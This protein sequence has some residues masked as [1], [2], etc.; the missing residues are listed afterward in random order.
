MTEQ[1][2]FTGIGQVL[3]TLR[4]MSPEQACLDNTDIDTRTDIYA[5]G[6]ILYELLTGTTPLEDSSI[7]GQAALRVLEL[8]REHE[9]LKPSRRLSNSTQVAV[10]T[11]T[12]KRRTDSVRLRRI[13]SGDL[14]WIVM[15]A[16]EKD[17]SRRYDS[18]SGFA[19]DIRRYVN[20]EPVAARPPSISYQLKKF[21]R[22]NRVA[23]T[24]GAAVVAAIV[25]GMLATGLA[26]RSAITQAELAKRETLKKDEALAEEKKQRELAIFQSKLAEEQM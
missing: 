14:D 3:G 11:I 13:L 16:L 7:E 26:L 18:A 10:S 21:V 4:Y 15:K 23:V 5:L 12:G 8:I 25:F 1:S 19:S 20:N 24:A 17:R 9:P 22:K 2:L 6:V